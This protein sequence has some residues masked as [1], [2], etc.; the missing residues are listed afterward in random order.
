EVAPGQQL[1]GVNFNLR[2]ARFATIRGQVIGPPGSSLNAGLLIATETGS[3]STGGGTD[4]KDGRFTFSSVPPG[5]IYVTGGYTIAGR[6]YDTMIE[7]DVGSSD[8]TGLELRPVAPMDLTGS[9]RIAGETPIKPSQLS[10]SLQGPSAGH[11]ETSSAAIR[12]DGSL[13]FSL[14][15]A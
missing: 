10:L 14:I 11:N 12:D 8:I 3:S 5:P 7:V 4:D 6:R 15:S 13:L 9:V 1:R 2:A